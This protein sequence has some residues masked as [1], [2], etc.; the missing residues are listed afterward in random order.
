MTSNNFNFLFT[1][2]E[3]QIL[4]SLLAYVHR[5]VEMKEELSSDIFYLDDS[6]E[7]VKDDLLEIAKKVWLIEIVDNKNM[8]KQEFLKSYRSISN[9]DIEKMLKGR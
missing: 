4:F 3:K 2:K 9:E 5:R 1:L 8:S 6:K 7:N